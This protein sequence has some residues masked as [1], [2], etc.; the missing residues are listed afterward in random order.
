MTEPAPAP[1]FPA[2]A[3]AL[4]EGGD[5]RTERSRAMRYVN[6]GGL[7]ALGVGTLFSLA[8]LAAGALIWRLRE[9]AVVG[10]LAALSGVV[11][12][13]LASRRGRKVLNGDPLLV[14]GAVLRKARIAAGKKKQRLAL[15]V[16]VDAA[17]TL[18]LDR[19]PVPR[20]DLCGERTVF[21]RAGLHAVLE[22]SPTETLGLVCLPTGEALLRWGT[23]A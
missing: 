6:A 9:D 14:V 22:P 12:G 20:P 21:A 10:G 3:T 23:Q 11:A 13:L 5:W 17:Y 16:R 7:V 15:V 1:A 19:G 2:H 8:G 4:V 18:D